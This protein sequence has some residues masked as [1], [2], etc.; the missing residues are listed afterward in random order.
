MASSP[1][2]E[3]FRH[4]VQYRG[5]L[6]NAPR[7]FL[8]A[9]DVVDFGETLHGGRIDVHARTACHAVKNDGQSDGAR[10][11]AIVLVKTF[12]GRLVVVGRDRKDAVDADGSEFARKRDNF[13][14]VVA[15]GA[16]EHRDLSLGNIDGEFYD[17]KMFFT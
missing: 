16:G 13:G 10:D 2:R 12:L 6:R 5:H 17:A 9:D 7:C 4:G 15:P 14:S 3:V 11:R 8:D 1:E